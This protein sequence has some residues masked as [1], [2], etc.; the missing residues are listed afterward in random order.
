MK[1]YVI[2]CGG[3]RGEIHENEKKMKEAKLING[4]NYL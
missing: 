2:I 1:P 3:K 4:I